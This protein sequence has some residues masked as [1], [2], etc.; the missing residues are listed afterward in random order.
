MQYQ[1]HNP[2]KQGAGH[3]REVLRL[4]LIVAHSV[5]HNLY[6][7]QLSAS[8]TAFDAHCIR[9]ECSKMCTL[10][11]GRHVSFGLEP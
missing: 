8:Q 2:S 6:I 9:S 3:V 1:Y 4:A 5:R 10:S 11:F 7:Y